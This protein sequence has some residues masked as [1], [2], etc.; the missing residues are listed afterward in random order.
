VTAFFG[1]FCLICWREADV[2]WSCAPITVGN[3]RRFP[4]MAMA[5]DGA[6]TATQQRWR[7][8]RS[9]KGPTVPNW[10]QRTSA[11]VHKFQENF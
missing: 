6:A 10:H 9:I 11:I 5:A 8:L 7:V 3:R 2:V 1:Y 4:F